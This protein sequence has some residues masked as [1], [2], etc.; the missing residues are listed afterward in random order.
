L[1][2]QPPQVILGHEMCHALANSSGTQAQGTDPSPPAS[3]PNIDQEE[4][5]AIGTGSHNG[6]SPSENAIRNDLGLPRRDNHF[7]TGGPTAGEPAPLNLR[8]GAPPL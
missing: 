3:E 2:P 6:Q 1:L 7:G 8:P 4:A 5:Q